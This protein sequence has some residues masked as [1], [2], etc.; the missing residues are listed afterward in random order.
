MAKSGKLL[1]INNLSVVFRSNQEKVSAVRNVSLQIDKG[2]ILALVGE[3]GSGKSVTALSVLKLLPY[4]IASHPTGNIKLDKIDLLKLEEPGLQ[5]I[6]G[7]RISM[8]FQEPM[9]SLNPLHTVKKQ[10]REAILLHQKI[11][12][13]EADNKSLDLLEMVELKGFAD[14]LGSY[15]HELSGGQRQRVMIAIALANDPELLIAD[16]PT[17]ALDVTIQAEIL[18]LLKNLQKNIGLS[19]LLITHDLTIVRKIADRVAVMKSGEVVEAG[20]TKTIFSKPEHPYTK[21]L[22]SSEPKGHP[23]K[24]NSKS[25]IVLK[26]ENLKVHFEKQSG[27][28]F[29]KKKSLIKAVDNVSFEVKAG[30]TLGVIGESGSGKSTLAYAI[31][32]L[33]KSTGKIVFIGNEISNYDFSKMRALRKNLQIVFQDPYASLNPRMTIKEAIAEGIKAHGLKNKIQTNKLIG[34]AIREVGLD[35]KMLERYPH[36]FSGGQ[37]QRI[38]IA[39]ALVLNPDFIILDEPTSALDL[40]TQ[41]EI[42][43]LLK[44]LQQQYK[45]TFMFISHDL[46]VIKS[47]SHDIIVMQNGRVVERGKRNDIF[48]KPKT[49][50]TKKLINA[51]FN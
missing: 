2:E 32:R 28:L 30:H 51:S 14:R 46:R 48:N 35:E 45:I 3:S 8:I 43:S 9:T 47:I 15:P 38:C 18:K 7:K 13:K 16:E 50:Y 36:E 23:V 41:S 20:K 11:S 1:T 17:T 26:A 33:I 19:I 22:I 27:F 24:I 37:R 5:K 29:T 6:R 42:I 12:L 21:H 44:N 34:K 31:L 39:R 40:T 10:L 25:K 49:D 4:P